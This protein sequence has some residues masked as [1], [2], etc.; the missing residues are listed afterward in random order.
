MKEVSIEE[1]VKTINEWGVDCDNFVAHNYRQSLVS[2][3]PTDDSVELSEYFL[4]CLKVVCDLG[5]KSHKWKWPLKKY[6]A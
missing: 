1:A 3:E 5:I 4:N 6:Q 2:G